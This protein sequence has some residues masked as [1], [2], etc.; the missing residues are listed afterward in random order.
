MS[1]GIS[2]AA[3]MAAF[4]LA[5]MTLGA[6]GY[7]EHAGV[8]LE[9]GHYD[10]VNDTITDTQQPDAQ[11]VGTQDP[12]FFGIAVGIYKTLTSLFKITYKTSSILQT[13]GVHYAIAHSIQL[14]VNFAIAIALIEVYR[15]FNIR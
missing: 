2:L 5:A 3:F 13:F 1:R 15:G 11:G 4:V 12:G 9:T 7:Y 10:T 14:M 6:T 8:D